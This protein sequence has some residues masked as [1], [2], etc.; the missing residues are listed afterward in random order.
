MRSRAARL[1]VSATA[2]IAMIAAA[3]FFVSTDNRI[4]SR[5]DALEAFELG[6]RSTSEA[7]ANTR[8]GLQAYV[9]AGQD[10]ASWMPRV[11]ALIRE[12][13]ETVDALRA[14]ATTVDAAQALIDASSSLT[15]VANIDKRVR[16]YLRAGEALMASDVVFTEG[17]AAAVRA[18]ALIEAARVSEAQSFA[19]DEAA[20][21]QWKSYALAAAASWAILV[22]AVLTFVSGQQARQD[23]ADVST[24]SAADGEQDD[25]PLQQDEP[26]AAIIP[27]SR[28]DSVVEVT[29]LAGVAALC[30]ELSQVRNASDLQTF[31]GRAAHHLDA[32]GIVVWVGSSTGSD[33]QPVAA[34]GYGERVLAMMTPIPRIADNAAAAAYRDGTLHVVPAGPGAAPGAVVAPLLSI[35]GCIGAL[36]AEIRHGGESS[37][38]VQAV[39]AIIAAQLASV[40][41]PAASAPVPQAR[42]ASA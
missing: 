16:E 32:S 19:T 39:A 18:G 23:S 41:A 24:A 22:L 15:E 17:Q 34:H 28:E 30:T 11:A 36:T 27:S 8:S 9:A 13:S 38:A 4:A 42:A 2:W 35:D 20:G 12:S 26:I 29:T 33:L 6:A 5:R 21:R 1:S 3:L 14:T 10:A 40:L 25:L 31:L 37:P 7:L